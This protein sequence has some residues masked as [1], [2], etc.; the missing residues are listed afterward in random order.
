MAVTTEKDLS[1]NAK[2]TW[3]KA[4]AQIETRNYGY[5]ISLIQTILKEFPG[6]SGRPE[7]A[8]PR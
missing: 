1:P 5:A 4:I 3:L 7:M 2:I 6:F 8:A